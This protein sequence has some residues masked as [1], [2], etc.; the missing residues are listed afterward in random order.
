MWYLLFTVISDERILWSNFLSS[1][2]LWQLKCM[3]ISW[4]AGR[5]LVQFNKRESIN[6]APRFPTLFLSVP[7]PTF[8]VCI[9]LIRRTNYLLS[10]RCI[11]LTHQIFPIIQTHGPFG[12]FSIL[13]TTQSALMTSSTHPPIHT[14]VGG[15]KVPPA[16]QMSLTFTGAILAKDTSAWARWAGDRTPDPVTEGRSCSPLT[17]SPSTKTC[18]ITDKNLFRTFFWV[19]SDFWGDY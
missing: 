12:H 4:H 19:I 8:A 3:E 17:H 10:S 7:T 18:N 2:L 15:A 11:M 1:V 16:H 9:Q 13:P 5:I 14:L 6:P